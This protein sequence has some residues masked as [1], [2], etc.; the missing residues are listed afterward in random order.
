MT[1]ITIIIEEQKD[2]DLRIETTEEGV[3]STLNERAVER[4]LSSIV[5]SSIQYSLHNAKEGEDANK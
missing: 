4:A 2:G 5:G 3:K 1:K